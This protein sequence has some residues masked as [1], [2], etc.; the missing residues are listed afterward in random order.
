MKFD[1]KIDRT[2]PLEP[3][4][5]ISKPLNGTIEAWDTRRD[6]LWEPTWEGHWSGQR[7][8]GLAGQDR[9]RKLYSEK[10]LDQLAA[11]N[12]SKAEQAGAEQNERAGFRGRADVPSQVDINGTLQ[13]EPR[14]RA[15]CET[16]GEGGRPVVEVGNAGR[17]AIRR[18]GPSKTQI[19][20]ATMNHAVQ[21][22]PLGERSRF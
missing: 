2:N 10:L 17:N 16:A 14:S 21:S 3:W 5:V 15:V 13:R 12:A 7:E 4:V 9:G 6:G 8:L 1:V 11:Q 20:K 18:I 22:M 19:D